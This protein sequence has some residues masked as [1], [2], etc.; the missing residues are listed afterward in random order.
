MYRLLTEY[1]C[2][3][4]IKEYYN[5]DYLISHAIKNIKWQ[6]YEMLLKEC[7]DYLIINQKNFDN[8]TPYGCLF[9]VVMDRYIDNN[10]Y[11][12]LIKLMRANF[13]T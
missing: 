12:R 4:N 11:I 8:T 2:D 9:K 3:P 7:K 13:P 6:A 10:D 1:N 5:K